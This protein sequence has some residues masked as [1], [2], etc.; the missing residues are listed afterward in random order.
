MRVCNFAAVALMGAASMVGCSQ[1]QGPPMADVSGV[2]AFDGKPLT[3]ATIRFHSDNA[4]SAAFPLDEAGHFVSDFPIR[5]GAY[6]VAVDYPIGRMP[7]GPLSGDL[8]KVPKHYWAPNYSGLSASVAVTGTN[9]F[10]F[11]ISSSSK[12]P[13][14]FK[15][16]SMPA[17][18]PPA[19]P[20]IENK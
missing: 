10:A 17:P 8:A 6:Q 15:P 11:D 19:P 13:A 18:P 5:A 3:G 1:P 12:A 14:G 7:G 20:G 4:G 2:V 16:K 9:D